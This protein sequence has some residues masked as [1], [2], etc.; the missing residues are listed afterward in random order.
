MVSS[1][2]GHGI[3]HLS[4]FAVVVY[5]NIGRAERIK[6]NYFGAGLPGQVQWSADHSNHAHLLVQLQIIESVN[7]VHTR[8]CRGDVLE[9]KGTLNRVLMLL[10]GARI[11][12]HFAFPS[13]SA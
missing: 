10:P 8:G 6:V 2:K 9:S 4:C 11:S 1:G 7:S 5:V 12:R 3:N 13:R